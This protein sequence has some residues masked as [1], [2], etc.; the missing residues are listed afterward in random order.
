MNLWANTFF[1]YPSLVL[2]TLTSLTNSMEKLND[3]ISM[4]LGLLSSHPFITETQ[5]WPNFVHTVL[6]KRLTSGLALIDDFQNLIQECEKRIY[7]FVGI[8]Q[9]TYVEMQRENRG[10]IGC[11]MA[12][13]VLREFAGGERTRI[14]EAGLKNWD[15]NTNKWVEEG[16]KVVEQE[17]NRVGEVQ[18]ILE[19]DDWFWQDDLYRPME[20]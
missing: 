9:G 7:S 3:R 15:W 20:R 2:H 13:W 8:P 14:L 12:E 18:W 6:Y 5:G 16:M 19:G 4:I 1:P 17:E 10:S 11:W